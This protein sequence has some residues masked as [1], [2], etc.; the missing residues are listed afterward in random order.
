MT[1]GLTPAPCARFLCWRA[2]CSVTGAVGQGPPGGGQQGKLNPA[3][4][5]PMRDFVSKFS[6]L[7][8]DV[9]LPKGFPPQRVFVTLDVNKNRILEPAE[10]KNLRADVSKML[11]EANSTGDRK[12]KPGP[13][14]EQREAM[15]KAAMERS[16]KAKERKAKGDGIKTSATSPP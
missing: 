4:P 10:M 9:E 16:A 13:T 1:G 8:P 3:R 12:G 2:F 5:V 11:A 6:D 7:L 14:P 15:K